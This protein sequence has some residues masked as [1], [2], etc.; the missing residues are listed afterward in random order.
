MTLFTSGIN[1]IHGIAEIQLT[2]KSGVTAS[3]NTLKASLVAASYEMSSKLCAY[4]IINSNS[5]LLNEMHFTETLL[6]FSPD[7]ILKEHCQLIYDRANA[8]AAA[9]VPYGVSAQ[10]IANLLSTLNSF[11]AY[12]PKPR[13]SRNEKTQATKQLKLQFLI[14]EDSISKIDALVETVRYSQPTFYSGYKASRKLIN[15]GHRSISLKARVTD[16]SD[17]K[18]LKGAHVKLLL[19][20]DVKGKVIER[21]TAEK[22]GVRVSNL[23]EGKYLISVN[24]PGYITKEMEVYISDS[25]LANLAI[26]MAR[27]LSA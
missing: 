22:G 7:N 27:R 5:I 21:K 2:D 14:L 24:L 11:I 15:T 6:K 3:K 8:N 18:P 16:A 26:P 13:L 9:L 23:T 25:E 19:A 4:A 20:E 17:N 10:V 1:Q 12:I